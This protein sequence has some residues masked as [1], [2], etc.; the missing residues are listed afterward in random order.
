MRSAALCH[1]CNPT[2]SASTEL[3]SFRTANSKS[4]Q[5]TFSGPQLTPPFWKSHTCDIWLQSI[6]AKTLRHLQMKDQHRGINSHFRRFV[7]A[8]E[9]CDARNL[10]VIA[11][12]DNNQEEQAQ[13]PIQNG[14]N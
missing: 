11:N 8:R 14:Q 9:K 5:H 4:S 2:M 3:L 13:K 1:D 7:G 6:A 10:R 12:D